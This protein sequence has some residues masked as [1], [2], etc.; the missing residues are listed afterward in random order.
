MMMRILLL[1]TIISGFIMPINCISHAK[2]EE[3]N[4]DV[5]IKLAD[6]C[7]AKKDY[8]QAIAM[9]TKA[10]EINPDNYYCYYGRGKS[11]LLSKGDMQQISEDFKKALEIALKIGYN[12]ATFYYNLGIIFDESLDN[13]SIAIKCYNKYLELTPKDNPDCPKIEERIRKGGLR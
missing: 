3:S 4:V 6:E 2:R 10:I 1:I 7:H 9:F 12:D 8:A 5:Y 11:R 13:P